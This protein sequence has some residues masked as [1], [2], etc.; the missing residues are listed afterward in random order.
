MS[1]SRLSL[2]ATPPLKDEYIVFL[3]DSSSAVQQEQFKKEKEFIKTLAEYLHVGTADKTKAAVI[4]Y[5]SLPV[6]GVKFDDYSTL[7][8]FK[9]GIDKMSPIQGNRRIDRALDKA[10]DILRRT[11]PSSSK[12]LVLLT[13]GRQ[14]QES[15]ITP[16]DVSIQPLKDMGAFMY[17]VA[18]GSQPSTRELRPLVVKLEDIF[19]VPFTGMELEVSRV[20]DHIREGKLI[21]FSCYK[22][23]CPVFFRCFRFNLIPLG[24]S[25]T[26]L[27][28]FRL[29]VSL[30]ATSVADLL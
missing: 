18:I 28:T 23:T 15:D 3:L 7:Q 16:L 20:V 6:T 8:G 12:L 29:K 24:D 21:S 27:Q 17:V 13:T 26:L 25:D 11:D 22:A 1:F 2:S 14:A 9:S 30:L 19:R 4:N 5:G 10:A